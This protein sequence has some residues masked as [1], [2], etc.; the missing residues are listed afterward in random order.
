MNW[1]APLLS[2][3]TA[4]YLALALAVIA[5]LSWLVGRMLSYREPISDPIEEQFPEPR[6]QERR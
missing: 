1:N 4:A 5:A 6:P 2:P 3:A